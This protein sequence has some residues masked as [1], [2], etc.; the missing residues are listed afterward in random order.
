MFQSE[1][2]EELHPFGQDIQNA[3]NE[4]PKK[5]FV[6]YIKKK[7]KSNI[8]IYAFINKLPHLLYCALL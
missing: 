1:L 5:K 4:I 6:L 8:L 7:K 3:H 2:L